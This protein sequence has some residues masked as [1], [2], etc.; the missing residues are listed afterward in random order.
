MMEHDSDEHSLHISRREKQT[1][2]AKTKP[3]CCEPMS[4]RKQTNQCIIRCSLS[5]AIHAEVCL[6]DGM[7][8]SELTEDIASFLGTAIQL[9]AILRAQG[10]VLLAREVGKEVILGGLTSSPILLSSFGGDPSLSLLRSRSPGLLRLFPSSRGAI[11]IRRVGRRRISMLWWGR[12]LDPMS[13]NPFH[14]IT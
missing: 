6:I 12:V 7:S 10:C 8:I 1:G 3:W 13:M 14:V 4:R 5:S 11:S 2:P 9:G